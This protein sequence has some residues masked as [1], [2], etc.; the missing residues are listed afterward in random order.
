MS[1]EKKNSKLREAFAEHTVATYNEG[2]ADGC[3]LIAIA[4]GLGYLVN[5]ALSLYRR[6]K[7]KETCKSI[8]D[9]D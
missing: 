4:S 6:Q 2:L 7:F 5:K 9:H 1:E 8:S 3:K